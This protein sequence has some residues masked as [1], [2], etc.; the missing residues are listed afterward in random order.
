[1]ALFSVARVVHSLEEAHQPTTLLCYPIFLE[2]IQDLL[3][4]GFGLSIGLGSNNSY[5]PCLGVV[6]SVVV[7]YPIG[8]ELPAIVE[9]HRSRDHEPCYDILSYETVNLPLSDGC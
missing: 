1:M 6:L 4:S 5:E 7:S 9:Y 3:I 8:I 2:P